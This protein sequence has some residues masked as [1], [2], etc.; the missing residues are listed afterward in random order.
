M[1]HLFENFNTI[2]NLIQIVWEKYNPALHGG[3]YPELS[4]EERSLIKKILSLKARELSYADIST[5]INTTEDQLKNVIKVFDDDLLR[6]S[7]P[8]GDLQG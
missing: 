3:D 4:K 1:I 5:K 2:V 6:R 8:Q 7:L